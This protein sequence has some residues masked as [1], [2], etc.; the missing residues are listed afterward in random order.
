M[1][2]KLNPVIS[3]LELSY[4]N[5]WYE[6]TLAIDS[7]EWKKIRR[8]VIKRAHNRCSFCA[9]GLSKYLT[10]DHID[11]DATNNELTNLRANC[12]ACDKIRHCGL[13]GINGELEVWNSQFSQ[14]EIVQLTHDYFLAND[15]I[16]TAN[17]IDHTAQKTS[18]TPFEVASRRFTFENSKQDPSLLNARAFFTPKMDFSYLYFKIWEAISNEPSVVVDMITAAASPAEQLLI[19]TLNEQQQLAVLCQNQKICVIAGPGCGKTKTL[20]SRIIFLV[21]RGVEIEQILVL[22]FSRKAIKEIRRRVREQLPAS[23]RNSN[24]FNLH[25]FCYNFLRQ[26]ISWLGIKRDFQICDQDQQNSLIK[27]ILK[28]N[29]NLAKGNDTKTIREIERQIALAK[30]KAIR[31]ARLI[32]FEDLYGLSRLVAPHYQT[33]LEENEMLDFTDLLLKTFIILSESKPIREQTR[34][35]FSHL[36]IDEFQDINNIQW[37]IIN[38]LRNK[39]AMLFLVGD[40]NQSIYGFQGSSPDL[41][42]SLQQ[43]GE[44]INIYL[45]INYRSSSQIVELGNLFISNHPTEMVQNQLRQTKED[46]PEVILAVH[47]Q[48]EEIVEKIKKFA[49]ENVQYQEMAVIYRNNSNSREIE[50]VLIKAKIPYEVL[51]SFKFIERAEIKDALAYLRMLIHNNNDATIRTLSLVESIGQTTL[52]MLEETARERELSIL[53]CLVEYYQ[54]G[55]GKS[56][57]KKIRSKQ[58]ENLKNFSETASFQQSKIENYESVYEF[59]NEVLKSFQ[60]YDSL[61]DEEERLLNIQQLLNMIGNWET[62]NLLNGQGIAERTNEFL[63]YLTIS[64]EDGQLKKTKDNLILTTVHQAKGLEFEVVFFTYLDQQIIPSERSNNSEVEEKRIFYVGIT[65]AKDYL[66]LVSNTEQPSLFLDDL[67]L[68]PSEEFSGAKKLAQSAKILESLEADETE[69]IKDDKERAARNKK[70]VVIRSSGFKRTK[71]KKKLYCILEVLTRDGEEKLW[72][73]KESLD[74]NKWMLVTRLQNGSQISYRARPWKDSLTVTDLTEIKEKIVWSTIARKL[75]EHRFAFLDIE[76]SWSWQTGNEIVEIGYLIYEDSVLIMQKSFLVKP[77][78]LKSLKEV[79]V[80]QNISLTALEQASDWATI[81]P[82]IQSD[83]ANSVLVS[84][85][86]KGFDYHCLRKGGFFAKDQLYYFFDTLGPAKLLLKENNWDGKSDLQNLIRKIR[87]DEYFEEPHRALPDALLHK[88]LFDY[89]MRD[90]YEITLL[91]R[92]H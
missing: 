53:A 12:P 23:G 92:I 91:Y 22:T 67:G 3:E 48:I 85:N 88:E 70:G 41:I 81:L 44:W 28:E 27:R 62:T 59:L 61:V 74:F 65:R 34:A 43:R 84:H 51:G 72:C 40:P 46:G 18:Q 86:F 5:S 7:P 4:T 63:N 71:E 20:I 24:I 6:R 77:S 76:T 29:L 19:S 35:H 26:H 89:L 47:A 64:F 49:E 50:Q 39:D 80:Y 66:Y 60:Y 2:N 42:R 45:N 31:N 11:G 55:K 38:L 69:Q 33:Y 8:E 15:Q 25:G 83:L 30:I 52:N 37:E 13:A 17:Q 21:S 1:T 16:P 10:V 36:L 9:I 68:V 90:K 82:Q 56:F 75:T 58:A 78:N 73:W 32:N 87:G 79:N 54:G 14:T 57:G